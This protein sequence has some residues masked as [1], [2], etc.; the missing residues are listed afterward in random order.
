MTNGALASFDYRRG[1]QGL[2]SN[3]VSKWPPS[4]SYLLPFAVD[5]GKLQVIVLNGFIRPAQRREDTLMG[6]WFMAGSE[7]VPR[8][9]IASAPPAGRA[10]EVAGTERK[11]M[12]GGKNRDGEGKKKKST[13][14]SQRER[15]TSLA[16]FS[17]FFL[18]V[19]SFKNVSRDKDLN[20]YGRLLDCCWFSVTACC[21]CV[22]ACLHVCMYLK[23]WT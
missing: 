23:A 13:Q 4:T 16:H 6:F 1:A 2:G 19:C 17:S 21:S 20:V 11:S 14:T 15:H 10:A 3:S 12:L 18:S 7:H 9:Y 22:R 8:R 5:Q